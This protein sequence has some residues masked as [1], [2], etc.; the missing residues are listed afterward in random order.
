MNNEDIAV[1]VEVALLIFDPFGCVD[2]CLYRRE[3]SYIFKKYF[4]FLSY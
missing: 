3:A 4:P 2:Q 1:T